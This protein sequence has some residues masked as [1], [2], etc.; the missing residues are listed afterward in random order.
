MAGRGELRRAV[1]RVPRQPVSRQPRCS[2]LGPAAA[3]QMLEVSENERVRKRVGKIR[4]GF[5]APF[6]RTR[7][8]PHR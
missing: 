1:A 2:G 7:S 5:D 6:I 8:A 3:A 4:L